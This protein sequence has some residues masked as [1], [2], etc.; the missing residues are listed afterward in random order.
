MTSIRCALDTAND[1]SN[2]LLIWFDKGCCS[3]LVPILAMSF[4]ALKYNSQV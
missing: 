3:V 1:G 2:H 4:C